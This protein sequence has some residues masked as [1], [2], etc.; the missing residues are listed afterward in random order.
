MLKK[1]VLVRTVLKQVKSVF[2]KLFFFPLS[3]ISAH[4]LPISCIILIIPS[5]LIFNIH[6]SRV[7]NF[8]YLLFFHKLL[9]LSK[10]KISITNA[11]LQYH[12]NQLHKFPHNNHPTEKHATYLQFQM[13]QVQRT[14]RLRLTAIRLHCNGREKRRFLLRRKRRIKSN[15][16]GYR[17]VLL[18]Y[19]WELW[20]NYE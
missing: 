17:M 1:I 15:C 13:L 6:F 3:F 7:Y 10:G 16:M 2:F 8:I 4:F 11:I 12:V 9:S 14:L 5:H 20:G 19:L 18:R